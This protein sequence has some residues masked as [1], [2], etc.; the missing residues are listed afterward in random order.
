M[1]NDEVVKPRT[2]PPA[3]LTLSK[4]NFEIELRSLQSPRVQAG[5][6]RYCLGFAYKWIQKE[7]KFDLFKIFQKKLMLGANSISCY[8]RSNLVTV[9]EFYCN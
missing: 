9:P 6:T 5:K 3:S 7:T 4:N 2:N 8:L 1:E